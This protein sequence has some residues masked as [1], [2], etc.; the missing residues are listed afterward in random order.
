MKDRP[1][2]DFDWVDARNKCSA[3]AVFNQLRSLAERD[4]ATRN[5]QASETAGFTDGG[6]RKFTVW[7]K[8]G[9]GQ[10]RHA[11]DFSLEDETISVRGDT[12]FDVT[13]TLNNVGACKCKV[14]NEEL[15]PWHVLKKALEPL[16]FRSR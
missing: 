6:G 16:L 3:D 15:D 9:S 14:D 1:P 7:S 11:A 13:L 10:E 8:K 12:E 2:P 4:V 5:A